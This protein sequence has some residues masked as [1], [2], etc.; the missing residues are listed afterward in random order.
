MLRLGEQ[1]L[2]RVGRRSAARAFRGL[3]AASRPKSSLATTQQVI[4]TLPPRGFD[5]PGKTGASR[6]NWEEWMVNLRGEDAWLAGPRDL[7]WYTGK[8]P[9][10]GLCPGVSPD[11]ALRALPMPNLNQVTRK[12]VQEYFDNSWTLVE[13]LFAG[14]HGEEPFYRPPVHGLRHPQIFY[15]GHTPCFYVNKL[16]VA[17]VLQDPVDPYME[18]VME[19]GVD[20]ML[21]DDMHKNDMVW[22][23]V[24]E[25]QE[26]RKKVY[27]VV[28]DVI[29]AHPD[30]EDHNGTSPVK[31][32]W[33]HPLWAIFMGAEH[34]AIHL[35]TSS[36]LFRETPSHLMQVPAAWPALHPSSMQSGRS[37]EPK[38]GEDFPKNEMLTVKGEAV[39]LGKPRD[40]PSYGWDNEYGHRRVQVADFAASK[41]LI[42]NGEFWHFVAGGGYRTEK[43]WSEDGW[44]WRKYRNM[45]WPFFWKQDGPQ[46]SMQFKLR[47][48][49]EEIDMVWSWPVD[50]NYHEARAFCAWKSEQDGLAGSPEAYRVI[51]EAEHQL[52]RHP[53][54]RTENMASTAYDRAMHAG[55]E[56]YALSGP[57]AANANLTYASQSPVDA[58]PASPTG[59]HDAMG[60]VWEWTEDHFNPLD[61]FKV[62]Y[63]Y[64]DFSTPCFDGRHHMIMGG[65]YISKSDNGASGFCRY[66]FRPHFLQHSGFRLVSSSSPAPATK[67]DGSFMQTANAEQAPSAPSP[68]AA[69][70]GTG[71][72]VAGSGGYETQRL[73]DQ[74]LGLHFP[75]SHGAVDPI[76][77]HPSAP[78]HALRFPQ[79]V[80]KMLVEAAVT[81]KAGGSLRALDIGCA[82]GGS[83]FELAAG[84]FDEVLGIDFSSAFI[85]AANRMKD[86]E[87]IRFKLPLEGEL[88]TEITAAHE[89]NVDA[90]VRQRVTFRTGDACRL[91]DQV[92]ELGR[93]DGALLANLLCRLPDPVACLDGLAALLRPGA[94]AVILTPFS[95]LEDF[96][97]KSKWLGGF[98][99]P[100]TQTPVSSKDQ[101][102]RLMEE[103]GFKK[104]GDQQVPLLIRE[105]QRKY[106]YIV[107]EATIWRKK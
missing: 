31:I 34:E 22:P 4:P 63:T 95:W 100:I 46:G 38:V 77:G 24:K 87:E 92:D 99:D 50:V 26:Y 25:V 101:L 59:H 64:D 18:S 40:F 57:N 73:V 11:G 79:R 90:A 9:V 83:S 104:I 17:G 72:A 7:S 12:Q 80:A 48:I 81:G 45:K 5:D 71:A 1:A 98:V 3:T 51:T 62:H 76:L 66:H 89:P 91:K 54:A 107:S 47:T 44:N 37:S 53:E 36:V 23:T 67:L 8:P 52:I 88:E 74:Y 30:L 32:T 28:S 65:S 97:P 94:A 21:W 60:N 84:G 35:E 106:Q 29:A 78:E 6:S 39:N 93:F 70:A 68:S 58:L 14:F 55:G 16:R 43:Y 33:D 49:F 103:R 85:N 82:V 69:A 75:S 86:A 15:Y 19:V 20:E 96:T 61:G 13:V 56:E 102:Q 10:P 2:R 41:Y 42:T 105:H 27:K